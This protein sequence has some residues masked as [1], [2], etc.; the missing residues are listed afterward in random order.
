MSVCVRM[1]E[2]VSFLIIVTKPITEAASGRRHLPWPIDSADAI[3]TSWCAKHR[4]RG[5]GVEHWET[6]AVDRLINKHSVGQ[7]SGTQ[8]VTRNG[9]FPQG[10]PR[11]SLLP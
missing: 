6:G 4:G 3:S 9:C 11:P 1:C 2:C 5:L 7:E 10:L 8:A